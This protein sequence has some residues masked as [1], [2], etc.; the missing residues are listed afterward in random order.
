L[1]D[2]A[3]ESNEEKQE[4]KRKKLED[5]KDSKNFVLGEKE[6]LMDN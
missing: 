3:L 5:V 4:L 1:C 6:H 2:Q